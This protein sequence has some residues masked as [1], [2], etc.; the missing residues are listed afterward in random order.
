[1]ATTRPARAFTLIETLV[2]IAIISVL[3]SILLPALGKARTASRRTL[4]LANARTLAVSF[5]SYLAESDDAYP[6]IPP[7]EEPGLGSRVL[8]F[9]WWPEGTRVATTD[10]FSGEWAWPAPLS[11]VAPWPEHYA[12]WVSPGRDTALPDE[13]PAFGDDDDNPEE[14]VSWRV[15]GA[16]FADPAVWNPDRPGTDERLI[17]AVRGHEVSFPSSKVL[18]WDTHLA[19]LRREPA[20]REGHWDARTPMGF[21]DGHADALNP[22]DARP[23]VANALRGGD[24]RRL[25][26]TPNGVQGVDY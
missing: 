1:M 14:L 22:L 16:F 21:A 10:L 15:S 11:A 12:T 13:P 4:A 19:F 5:E 25:H 23:G 17:R 9:D 2:V 7:T 8:A 18:A 24:D 3:I 20:L 26:N 6:F